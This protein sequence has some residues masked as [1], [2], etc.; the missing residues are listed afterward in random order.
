MLGHLD[1]MV[2]S[3]LLG[4]SNRGG[5]ISRS[6]AISAG[7]ALIARYSYTTSQIEITDTWAQSLLRRMGFVRRAKTSSKV[8]IPIGARKEIEFQF[9][10]QVVSLIEQ[11]KIQM[12]L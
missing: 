7:K 4:V 3:Y 1:E 8:D 12:T 5:A 6:V 9:L 2:Q 10:H 11:Y